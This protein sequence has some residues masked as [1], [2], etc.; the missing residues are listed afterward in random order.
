MAR[1]FSHETGNGMIIRS[2]RSPFNFIRPGWRRA[3][4]RIHSDN[5]YVYVLPTELY[6]LQR[7]SRPSLCWAA[8]TV[9]ESLV[10]FLIFAQ[11]LPGAL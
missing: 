7:Y 4:Q 6:S 10:A 3:A 11:L 1:Q 9:S 2:C 5:S 8:A